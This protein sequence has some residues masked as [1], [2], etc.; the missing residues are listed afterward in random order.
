MN[1]NFPYLKTV[2]DIFKI[3]QENLLKAFQLEKEFHNA[4]LNEKNTERRL[5]LY[6]DIYAKVHPLYH[7]S[8][9][10]SIIV[11]NKFANFFKKEL[12]EKSILDVGCGN[13]R[14]LMG[15]SEYLKTK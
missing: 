4:I 1:N 10:E 13:G 14:I 12:S 7:T 6:A 2:S 3:P 15:I 8:N 5:E 9:S 11:N